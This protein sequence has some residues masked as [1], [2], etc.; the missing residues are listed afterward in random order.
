MPVKVEDVIRGSSAVNGTCAE[1]LVRS[2]VADIVAV[3]GCSTI[4]KLLILVE[5]IGAWSAVVGAMRSLAT[6][7]GTV[8]VSNAAAFALFVRTMLAAD[9]EGN[10]MARVSQTIEV[11]VSVPDATCMLIEE[12]M[13]L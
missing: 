10:P 1:G 6:N 4:V 9:A 7:S 13:P 11:A 8:A 2:F 5:A 12:G 3:V